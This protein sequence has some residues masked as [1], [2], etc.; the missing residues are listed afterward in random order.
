MELPLRAVFE[1]PTP[2]GLAAAVKDLEPTVDQAKI[3]LLPSRERAPATFM[4]RRLWFLDQLQPG[5][6]VYHL[7]WSVRLTGELDRDALQSALSALLSRHESLRTALVARAGEPAQVIAPTLDVPLSFEDSDA[8]SLAARLQAF[9][10]E[11]FDL[12][13]PPLW[14]AGVFRDGARS[15]VLA[16]VIHHIVADGWSLSV[17]FR[18]LGALYGAARRGEDAGLPALPLQYADYAAWQQARLAGGELER[19]LDY[20]RGRLAGAPDQLPL[21][22][23]RPRPRLQ[24]HRGARRSATVSVDTLRALQSVCAAQGVTLYMVLLASF[25]SVLSRWTGA[26]DLVVGTP[27]AGRTRKEFEAVVGFFVNTL[28]LRG[29]VSGNPDLPTVLQRARSA[30]LDAFAHPDLP[31][32]RLVDELGLPRDTSRTPLVQVLFNLHNEPGGAL[33]M[34]GLSTGAAPVTRDTA[35][36][37]LSL[38]AREQALGL[39][40]VLEY[41]RDLF[42]A[43]T[44]DWLLSCYAGVLSRWSSK[45]SLRLGELDVGGSP[46][47][48]PAALPDFAGSPDLGR[49]FLAQVSAREK[50]LAVADGHVRWSYGA[51]AGVAGRVAA[52][53]A[54]IGA[55]GDRVGLVASPNAAGIAG[56]LGIV[57]AGRAYVALDPAQPAARLRRLAA[58]CR[59]VVSEA[60][61]TELA[62]SLG[63][64]V[65]AVEAEAGDGP[66]PVPS[67]PVPADTP[68]YV[69]HT[70]GST[71]APKAV[72]QTQGG[73]LRQVARYVAGLGIGAEDRLSLVSSLGFDAAVQDVFGALLSGASVHPV[74]LRDADSGAAVADALVSAGV[75]VFHATPTVY[76]YVFGD[77]LS[78]RHELSGIRAVVLGGEVAR[79]SDWALFCTR[80][81]RGTRLVNGYGLTESTVVSQWQGD[82]DSRVSGELLPLGWPVA[83]I[84]VELRDASGA[85]SWQGEIVLRGEGLAEADAR[86]EY[87][88][89]DLGRWQAD[90]QL[91]W[92]GRREWSAQAE[93]C[94]GAAGRGRV[95]AGP[96]PGGDGLRGGGSGPGRRAGPGGVCDG[97]GGRRGAGSSEGLGA[98]GAGAVAVAGCLAA[99]GSVAVEGQRQAGRE[100]VAG[101]GASGGHAAGGRAG[102][103]A[104]RAVGRAAGRGGGAARGRFFCARRPFPDGHTAHRADTCRARSRAGPARRFRASAPGATGRSARRCEKADRRADA[105]APAACRWAGRPRSAAADPLGF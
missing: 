15:Q 40:L 53:V 35:K 9:V 98:R 75:T 42:D 5:S 101:A 13:E 104:G 47:P 71:G 60:S 10:R 55:P 8:E 30:S 88:T 65:I 54:G 86:G 93:R 49:A 19:Q 45:P 27:I 56:M 92:V 17:L 58:G 70:S 89:G 32:E 52:S 28:V 74:D 99:A 87:R 29:D 50:S 102:D 66:R 51:L 84:E 4:Q 26:E 100:P 44:M 46:A 6:S 103:G 72:T 61:L 59:A 23:D 82:H 33:K 69:L 81:A 20:W 48:A 105:G 94:A 83:G 63:A 25:Q 62:G 1:A 77:E 57:L 80:F 36:F 76:R 12:A 31:F 78:C 18:E 95:G 38:S 64:E 43:V 90:G 22:T 85:V 7:C 97:P 73:V 16:L 2:E 14:R 37:D 21:P 39:E 41:D 34:D 91:A 79:R 11:P 3:A 67:V 96:G 24:R 68:A